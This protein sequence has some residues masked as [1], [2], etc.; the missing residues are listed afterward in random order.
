M[1]ID[2][3]ALAR[4]PRRRQ[5]SSNGKR[6]MGSCPQTSQEVGA[7]ESWKWGLGKRGCISPCRENPRIREVC[8]GETKIQK[9]EPT[10]QFSLISQSTTVPFD[11]LYWGRM[12]EQRGFAYKSGSQ[13]HCAPAAFSIPS[14][15]FHITGSSPELGIP[16]DSRLGGKREGFAARRGNVY[17]VFPQGSLCR[18]C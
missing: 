9:L 7:Q 2:S 5:P 16:W 11:G 18:S 13:P 4:C 10:G 6:W 15:S 14:N 12:R 3:R 17:G 1:Q 8:V